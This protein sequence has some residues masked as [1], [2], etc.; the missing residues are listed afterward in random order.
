V[1]VS[2][3][4]SGSGR[5][6]VVLAA[7]VAAAGIVQ[8]P[9]LSTMSKHGAGLFEFELMRTPERAGRLLDG[10]GSSGVSAARLSSGIDFLFIAAYAAF[11]SVAGSAL[12]TRLGDRRNPLLARAASLVGPVGV[13]AAIANA[14]AKT[15]LLGVVYGY[16]DGPAPGI[17]FVASIATYVLLGSAVILAGLTRLAVLA[18]PQERPPA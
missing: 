6:L 13:A 3:K 17:A 1:E 18:Q 9:L 8:L 4:A 5:Q 11:F 15:A 7:I 14:V 10:W 2:T 16:P 12:R